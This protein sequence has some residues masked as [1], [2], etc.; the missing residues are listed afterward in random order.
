[1]NEFTSIFIAAV[2]LAAGVELWLAGRQATAVRQHRA[3]VPMPFHERV[4]LAAHQRAADYVGAKLR[5]ERAETI[6]G[7]V[8]VAA[9]TLGGGIDALAGW[10]G[11]DGAPSL[12]RDT[13]YMLT[14]LLIMGAL[15]LPL[16]IYRTFAIEARFGFNRI[17][18]ALY[19]GDLVKHTLIFILLGGPLIALLLWLLAHTDHWWLWGWFAWMGFALLMLWA[20]P[21]L[22]A[23]LFNRFT[24]LEDTTLR[25]RIENL[26]HRCGFASGGV[27]V[28]DGSTR[29]QHGNAYFT[30]LG[31]QKRI[32]FFDT[33][34]RTL[35]P[36]EI[37]AVLA[38]ELGHFKHGHVKQ[39]LA[40]MAITSLIGFALLGWLS[41]ADWFYHGLG[42]TTPSHPTL[43]LLFLLVLPYFTAL[44][45]PLSSRWMRKH[46]FGADAYAAA[47]AEPQRLVD[48]LVKLYEENAATLTPDALYSAYHD[49]HP[50]A[51]V[52]IA[53]LLS[54]SA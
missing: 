52:R 33:L 15:G 17:T 16:E 38:H 46:E 44:L 31:A 5:L 54:A 23:P 48:A 1:M 42:V 37:E 13:G 40:F 24:P 51:P 49:S 47:H 3:H 26:L 20:Y 28:M 53:R 36:D 2:V 14:A 21:S 30:G 18:A 43:L 32:V 35:S 41:S 50:P 34:L 4:S 9:W 25:Q 12:W 8:L 11:V 29:S 19:I 10:W 7:A 45:H 22:I 39:R 27:Y 6:V